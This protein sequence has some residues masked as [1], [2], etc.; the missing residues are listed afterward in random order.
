MF[1]VFPDAHTH[2]GS[3]TESDDLLTRLRAAAKAVREPLKPPPYKQVPP[4]KAAAW[5][6]VTQLMRI[7]PAER[8]GMAPLPPFSW[9]TPLYADIRAH[10]F[11]D[12]LDWQALADLKLS[13]L[14]LTPPLDMT[15]LLARLYA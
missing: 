3:G 10:P 1:G 15:V 9:D 5:D 14:A 2:A 7:E 8:L 4:E 13:P 11:F 12:G 6:L